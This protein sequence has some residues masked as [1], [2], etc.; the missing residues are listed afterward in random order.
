GCYFCACLEPETGSPFRETCLNCKF[1]LE[2]GMALLEAKEL[3]RSDV[4]STRAMPSLVPS[5]SSLL[6]GAVVVFLVL[7]LV[8]PLL[9]ILQRSLQNTEGLFVGL[10][11][12]RAY[13]SHSSSL[14]VIGNSL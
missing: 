1:Q 14:R 12:Y 2:S 8:V 9:F 3:S 6:L 4:S 11:N 10:D 13:F 7:F 5:S